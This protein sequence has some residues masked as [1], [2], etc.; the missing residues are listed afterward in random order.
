MPQTIYPKNPN[1]ET[2]F[3]VQDDGTK[4]RALMIAPQDITSLELPKNANS[5][6]GYVTVD[7][8]KQR[9]ILTADISGNGGGGSSLPD[10]TGHSG[11][12][13]TTDGTDASWAAAPSGLPDQ[14]GLADG[15]YKLRLTMASGVGT[16]SW[17]AE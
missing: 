16:L 13:L 3:V 12:F 5:C 7:G 1:S 8:K 17:V 10:Q 2:A 11:E 6:K 15:N 14:T 4:N 9:V